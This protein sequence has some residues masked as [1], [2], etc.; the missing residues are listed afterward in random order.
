VLE[1]SIEAQ[2]GAELV[3]DTQYLQEF[4]GV[5]ALPDSPAD[6]RV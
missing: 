6:G 2:L 3:G 1:D 4:A 5:G